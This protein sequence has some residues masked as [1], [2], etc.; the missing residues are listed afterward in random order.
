ML[1]YSFILLLA[2][3]L[4]SA[5]LSAQKAKLKTIKLKKEYV[6]N[7]FDFVSE[8]LGY[9]AGI[10]L[11]RDAKLK[12]GY[13]YRG[14]VLKTTDGGKRWEEMMG[15]DSVRF[16]SIDMQSSGIGL[17][18]GNT[19]FAENYNIA[20]RSPD[21]G[22]SWYDVTP[23]V[24]GMGFSKVSWV[25]NTNAVI[26]GSDLFLSDDQGKTWTAKDCESETLPNPSFHDLGCLDGEIVL[27][28]GDGTFAYKTAIGRF[29]LGDEECIP[30]GLELKSFTGQRISLAGAKDYYLMSARELWKSTTQGD[31]WEKIMSIEKGQLKAIAFANVELGLVGGLNKLKLTRDGGKKWQNLSMPHGSTVNTIAWSGYDKAVMAGTKG[32][33]Y[34]LKL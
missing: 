32:V 17:V 14:V 26:M 8:D 4:F 28:G 21:R 31:Y 27:A 2:G 15:M 29:A 24:V 7:D 30:H 1:R 22:L 10:E 6:I 33:I 18:V 3:L 20:M 12:A 11:I 5:P 13:Y 9:A 16:M 23:E 25:D 19:L 34:I